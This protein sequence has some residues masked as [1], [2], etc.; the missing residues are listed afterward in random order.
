MQYSPANHRRL[1]EPAPAPD[2]APGGLRGIYERIAAA[3][4][5]GDDL[6]DDRRGWLASRNASA[7]R[8]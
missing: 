6:V 4:G 2:E 7:D 1:R 3:F 5:N 8:D